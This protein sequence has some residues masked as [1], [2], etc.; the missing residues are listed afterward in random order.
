MDFP[1]RASKSSY[2]LVGKHCFC[3]AQPQLNSTST[4]T[5]AEVG[6]ISTFS[7]HPEQK[8]THDYFKISQDYFKDASRLL[9]D[10][11]KT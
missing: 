1:Y 3:K 6:L 9:Q 7:T 10:Y 4:Q 8:I 2:L 11:F 5:Q